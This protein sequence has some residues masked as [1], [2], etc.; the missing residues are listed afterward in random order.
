VIDS[1]ASTHVTSRQDFFMSYTVGDFGTMKMGNDVL[2]KIIGIR[3]VCLEM[4][5]D[6]RLVLSHVKH[7]PVIRLN[8]IFCR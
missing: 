7:I 5:N 1:S 4:S 2:A 3:D 6:I 8:L